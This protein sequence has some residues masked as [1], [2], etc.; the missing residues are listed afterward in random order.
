M[1]LVIIRGKVSPLLNT[2]LNK[3]AE[4]MEVELHAENRVLK[5]FLYSRRQNIYLR[6][7]LETLFPL[8]TAPFCI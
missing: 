8:D 5:R 1:K 3:S 7:P 6:V 4:N 2:T